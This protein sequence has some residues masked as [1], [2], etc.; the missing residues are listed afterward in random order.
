[1][2]KDQII[3]EEKTLFM[4]SGDAKLC[5]NAYKL[6]IKLMEKENIFMTDVQ[7]LS[8]LSHLSAMVQRSITGEKL[9]Q[10]DR[11]LFADISEESL[12]IA[13]EVKEYIGNLEEDE[14]YL[15]SIHYETA[16]QNT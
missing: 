12:Q 6:S 3:D 5:E 9:F 1:M 14:I 13:K 11:S 16:K 8:L 15:L 10:I 7:R 2:K 4:K